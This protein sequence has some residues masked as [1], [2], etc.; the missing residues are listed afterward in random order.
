MILLELTLAKPNE[1]FGEAGDKIMLSASYIIGIA[2]HTTGAR[3]HVDMSDLEKFITLYVKEEYD[4][5]KI[6]KLNP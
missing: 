3:V 2:P 1:N 6:L 4:K 5:W